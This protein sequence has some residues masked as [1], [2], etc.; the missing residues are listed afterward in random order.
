MVKF[1]KRNGLYVA[2]YSV[3]IVLV[4]VGTFF[5]L[6]IS[7]AIATVNGEKY[8]SSS[9]FAAVVECFGEIPVYI[10][11]SFALCSF[12]VYFGKK[13]DGAKKVLLT[14][15]F[16][17]V[18]VG[19][20]YYAGTRIVSASNPYFGLKEYAK[21]FAGVIFYLLFSLFFSLCYYLLTKKMTKN[22]SDEKLKSLAICSLIVVLT[23]ALSQ[24]IT[25][26]SKSI[27][28]RARY[29]YMLFAGK[30]GY[31][32]LELFTPW[33][34]ANSNPKIPAGIKE[35]VESGVYRS[36]PSGHATASFMLLSLTLLP[37]VYQNL[38]NKKNKIIIWC[39]V[40]VLQTFVSVMRIVAGA[41]FLTDVCFGSLI[42]LTA[43]LI[44]RSI[45]VK[46]LA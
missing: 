44:F 39:V 15:L 6:E 4:V 37:F 34:V 40:L 19:L 30:Q 31:D 1:L 17:T 29:R 43:F 28:N 27:F 21:G 11:P 2:I 22:L 42:T 33:Y 18:L 20:N 35:L 41:H 24:I 10:F 38:D 45:F 23:A 16:A 13:F 14:I 32:G 9:F 7:K 5:D 12:I 25:Q 3:L 36:F 8:F 46:K 26:G